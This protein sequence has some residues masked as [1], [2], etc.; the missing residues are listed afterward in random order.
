MAFVWEQRKLGDLVERI[1]K[2]N[3]DLLSELP[4]T[5]S[6][7]YGL[8]DQ[9]EFFDK[10]VASKDISGY[11][12]IKNGEFA[13]NKSTSTDA[14]WGAI[15]RLD[16]Y[17]TG[18]LSTLYIV[19]GIKKDTE[20][21]SNFLTAYY[22]TN[23]W[24]KE[25]HEIAAEGARNHGLLN[26]SPA[27]FFKTKL[28]TPQDL[29]EQNK[30]GNYFIQ[31][32]Q[33]ITLHQRKRMLRRCFFSIDWEQRKVSEIADRFDNLRVPVAANLRTPGTTPYYGANGIQDY[34]EGYTHD[35]EFV[36]VA[37]DGANDLK[38]YPVKCVNGRIWVNNHA[39][40]LQARPQ[41]ASNQFLAYSMS[42]ANI[43]ALLVG[44]GRAKLNAEVMMGI[45]LRIPRLQEQEVIGG[46]FYKLD[47]LITLHQCKSNFCKKNEVN[48]WEQRKFVEFVKNAAKKNKDNID[49]EPYAVTNDRGF[50]AQKDAHDDFGYMSNV[51]RTA[52][53]IVPPNSFAYNPARINVGSLGYYEGT[54]NVIVSSL[55][56]VFQTEEY[57]DDKFLLHWFKSDSFPRWIE[58]LQEGS[59]RLY[60][61]FDKLV[62]CQMMVPSLE[63]Q[64]RI[65]AYLDSIDQ[66]I[67]LHQ[68]E[69]NI[70]EN[71]E[72][73]DEKQRKPI[74]K[75]IISEGNL[76]LVDD[77]FLLHR[78]T[79]LVCNKYIL[80]RLNVVKYKITIIIISNILYSIVSL[81]IIACY[82]IVINKQLII[83]IYV[84]IS[85]VIIKGDD[86][87]ARIRS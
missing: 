64:K 9:K 60:F 28:S 63:E 66:L 45:V 10:R 19:F 77:M 31:L 1:T 14:P 42:Q 33:L 47:Q 20:L 68:W 57:I 13:Y 18:V 36:L 48:A 21:N 87:Y 53:N 27:D 12:L 59:V 29:K 43:E 30:I 65:S 86:D 50:I 23:L 40:V 41:I 58:K 49:L 56:E 52:Y 11:Y 16:R 80:L 8:I 69:C 85:V 22:S 15:K 73:N 6:A 74:K 24:H 7:Q 78:M 72:G 25:I 26:I 81:L 2:K 79:F 38:N 75:L 17:E 55:Y 61:Y 37:E 71:T 84:E 34:V 32:D 83:L 39:H 67:T 54:E 76:S 3:Q 4:L 46:Y 70:N 62:Q 82:L 5:I 44:G 51:D 35:G